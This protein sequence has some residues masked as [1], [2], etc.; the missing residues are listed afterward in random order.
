[1]SEPW[2]DAI[3]TQQRK[4][5]NA[6]CRDL[7]E[8][9]SW[10]GNRLSLDDWRHLISGTV[11]GWRMM[12]AIDMGQ[13]NAGFIMLGGSSLRLSK[14]KCID[15]ITMAFH[16]GDDPSSQGLKSPPVRWC[17]A[18]CKARWLVEDGRMAA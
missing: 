10:H 2:K 3:T 11:L 17:A 1:M 6:A 18:I 7:S 13:G 16:L 4:I 5:L 14:E 8:Q 12:P 9:I 15:A